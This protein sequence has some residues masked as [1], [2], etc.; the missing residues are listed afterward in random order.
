VL[1]MLASAVLVGLLSLWLVNRN[2]I[3]PIR[4]LIDYVAQLSQG[5]FGARV[6]SRREDELG[7]LARR[8]Y[9]ARFRRHLRPPQGQCRRSWT[10]PAASCN[11][12]GDMAG[13]THDQFQR[14]DQ[15]ATAMHEMSATAQEVARHAAEAARAADDADHSAQAGEQVMQQTIDI[16]G[17]VN[18]EIAGTAAVIRTWRTTARA[19]ARCSK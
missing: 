10:A 4:Q 19:S 1:V 6:D 8:Q 2:L 5:R 14:T 11:I 12:A 18:R 13:G 17:L 3:E 16:I 7:R 9:P 15:V